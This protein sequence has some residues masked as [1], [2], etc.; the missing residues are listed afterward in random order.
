MG[1]GI[2]EMRRRCSTARRILEIGG[3]TDHFLFDRRLPAIIASTSSKERPAPMSRLVGYLSNDPSR[4]R[5]AFHPFRNDLVVQGDVRHDGWGIGYFQHGEILLTKRPRA[6]RERVSA[7]ELVD[8][9]HTDAL[10]LHVREATVGSWTLDNTHPFRYRNWLFA[11]RG[12]LA[13]FAEIKAELSKRIPEFLMRNLRGETDSVF[14]FHLFLA[15]MRESAR[16]DDPNLDPRFVAGVLARTI[17]ELDTLAQAAGVQE[18]SAGNF[19]LTNGRIL[20]AARRGHPLHYLRREGIAECDACTVEDAPT[21]RGRRSAVSH[22]LLRYA[23]VACDLRA[24]I[25]SEWIE[26][27]D[28]SVLTLQRN[29]DAAV[30]PL[31]L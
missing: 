30:A 28:G 2:Y 26:V 19:V 24:P 25:S 11:H 10:L 9:L 1:R 13:A 20:V 5:C 6:S 31:A 16:S 15:R 17:H 21:S 8:A 29:L 14:A 12:T 27:P 3:P 7:A 22:P 18:P 23:L 4:V